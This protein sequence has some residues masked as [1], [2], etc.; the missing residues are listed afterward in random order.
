MQVQLNTK[1]T[2]IMAFLLLFAFSSLGFAVL[3]LLLGPGYQAG[4]DKRLELEVQLHRPP[5]PDLEPFVEF[6]Q[7]VGYQLY[8]RA[9]GTELRPLKLREEYAAWLQS[10]EEWVLVPTRPEL[11]LE[12]LLFQLCSE[13]LKEGWTLQLEALE[14]GYNLGFWSRVAGEQPVLALEWHLEELNPKNYHRHAGGAVAVLGQYFDPA[15]F[16]KGTPQAP[17]LAIII[18]DWGHHSPAAGPLLAYPLPLTAAV[19]PQ[20]ALTAELAQRAHQAGFEVLLHQPMEAL[21]ITLPLG[22]GGI[23]RDMGREEIASILA[24]NLASMPMAAGVSN[25]MGSLVTE[26]RAAM[27]SILEVVG[28]LGLFFVD[29]RTSSRSVAAVVA[30]ELGM[31]L[32][33]NDL[34]IDN[35]DDVEKIKTQLRAGLDLAR[36]RGWAVVIG[37]VRPATAD[38]LWAMLPELLSSG[39]ELVPISRALITPAGPGGDSGPALPQ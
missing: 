10:R 7:E 15:A 19:L 3:G 16:L 9:G 31:P 5:V 1:K 35:E 2:G 33:R 21:D 37:H 23:Y 32:G 28:E 30:A 36:R 24:Q 38:A 4:L 22:P 13:L 18:D 34:F 6:W 11:E 20:L 12:P 39:V 8:K 25:H 26:D 14:H 17:V 27:G 29:S